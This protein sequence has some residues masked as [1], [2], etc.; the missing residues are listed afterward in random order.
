MTIP[1]CI[2]TASTV[3]AL[4]GDSVD[5]GDTIDAS[6]L[7]GM[8]FTFVC[9]IETGTFLPTTDG[10]MHLVMPVPARVDSSG[11]LC[12]VD[13]ITNLIGAPG[14]PLL[15]DDPSLGLDTPLQWQVLPDR[16][17]NVLGSI[18]EPKQ[19]WFDAPADG[20]TRTLSSLTPVN[21]TPAQGIKG[22]P[23]QDLRIDGAVATYAAL[24]SSAPDGDVWL[25]LADN[26]LYVRVAGAWPANGS[27]IALTGPPGADGADGAPGAPGADGQPQGMYA[28]TIGNGVATTIT[29]THNL[30]TQD[31]IVG[32]RLVSTGEVVDVDP[33]VHLSDNSFSVTFAT[34]PAA[35]SVRVVVIGGA[36]AVVAG[37]IDGGSL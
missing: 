25:V 3:D 33:I 17:F 6:A 23:G 4:I 21:M 27:G 28:A 11:V 2:I 36:M 18:V 1:Q 14:V 20:T 37:D 15:A 16:T 26:K 30:G 10:G 8:N 19:W 29:V 34:A 7:A 22:D 35:S 9:N 31:L 13:P 32:F 24:P 5:I 12:R